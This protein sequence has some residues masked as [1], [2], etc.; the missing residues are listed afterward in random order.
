MFFCGVLLSCV[1]YIENGIEEI[2]V[3]VRRIPVEQETKR[4]EKKKEREKKRYG[5]E[6]NSLSTTFG[7]G[8]G[9]VTF[10]QVSM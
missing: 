10:P 8:S 3:R 6:G 1:A 7:N 2:L 5:K 4:K 9:N